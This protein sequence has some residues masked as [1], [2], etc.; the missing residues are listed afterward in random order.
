MIMAEYLPGQGRWNEDYDL[1]DE[2]HLYVGDFD[3]PGL[4]MCQRGWN[5]SFGQTYSIWRN[6][7]GETG[8]CL[9]CQRRAEKGLAGVDCRYPRKLKKAINRGKIGYSPLKPGLPRR[10]PHQSPLD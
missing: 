6:Q 5:R 8:I 1:D 2:T 9:V 10:L 3:S 7:I 4:P